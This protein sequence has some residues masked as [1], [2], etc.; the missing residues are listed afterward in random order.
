MCAGWMAAVS[1]RLRLVR[2]TGGSCIRAYGP[3]K[4][5]NGGKQP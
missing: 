1:I 4:K 3:L 2:G 5:R